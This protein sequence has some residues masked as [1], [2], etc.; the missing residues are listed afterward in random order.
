V[1]DFE[2]K[3]V[4]Y[5]PVCAELGNVV[6]LTK[7]H[8]KGRKFHDWVFKVKAQAEGGTLTEMVGNRKVRQISG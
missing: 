8:Y 1:E 6:K 4:Y 5:A 2:M 7:G 3:K